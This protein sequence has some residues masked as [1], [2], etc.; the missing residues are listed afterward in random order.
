MDPILSVV[1][2][3]PALKLNL[4]YTIAVV[5]SKTHTQKKNTETLNLL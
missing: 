2:K 5:F 3:N 4:G 1:M